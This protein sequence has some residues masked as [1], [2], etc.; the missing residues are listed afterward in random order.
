ALREVTVI[1]DVDADLCVLG[2]EYRISEVAG[3]EVVLLPEAGS[4]V[5]NVIFAIF[6]EVRAVGVDDG[7]GVVVNARTILF[8]ER[9][10]DD[11]VVF[12]RILLHQ[13]GRRP[14]G[15]RLDRVVP[16]RILLRAEIGTGENFLHADHLHA[17]ASGLIDVLGRGLDLRVATLPDRLVG[18]R[19][20]GRL[21]V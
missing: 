10:D 3:T 17:F 15:D 13:F 19:C 21:N 1:A 5:W 18:T 11:H 6:A 20:E 8:V 7:G 2:V 12:L 4:G 16:S 14:V 9:N